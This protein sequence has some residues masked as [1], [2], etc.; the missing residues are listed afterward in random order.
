[1]KRIITIILLALVVV[2]AM[3]QSRRGKKLDTYYL[4]ED[5]EICSYDRASYLVTVQ[6][7]AD[8]IKVYTTFIGN[9]LLYKLETYK[10]LNEE[11]QEKWGV[12]QLYNYEGKLRMHQYIDPRTGI[13][14]QVT[15]GHNGKVE[16]EVVFDKSTGESSAVLYYGN[17]GKKSLT[18]TQRSVD[19][20]EKTDF[21]VWTEDGRLAREQRLENNRTVYLVLFDEA[22][23]VSLKMPF[24]QNDT[25]YLTDE[26]NVTTRSNAKSYGIVNIEGDSLKFNVHNLAGRP[27]AL[28]NFKSYT[29][30]EVMVWG[31]QKVYYTTTAQ[32]T[33]SIVQF[34]A[35]DGEPLVE[36]KYYPDG[37]LMSTKIVTLDPVHVKDVELRQ[38]YP[39]GILRRIQKKH[40]NKI[41]E[42][43]LYDTQGNETFPFFE[44]V[45]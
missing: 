7:E 29:P 18:K 24:V 31:V 4:N 34:C 12:Q 39:S 2:T 23:K 9:N 44:F 21:T 42:G 25:I 17:G 37:K 3:G 5:N 22:G 26:G 38:Y 28:Q 43:H 14:S 15:F 13:D 10:V 32:P 8:S 40:D 6:K 27:T 1:M 33:D 11:E 30:E 36:H 20:K 19:G 45:E 35:I 41:V 16:K